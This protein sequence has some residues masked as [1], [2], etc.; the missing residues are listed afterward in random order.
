MSRQRYSR[1]FKVEAAKLVTEQGLSKAEAARRLGVT[2]T[3]MREWVDQ[4]G[5]E[6]G[7]EQADESAELKRLRE[8]NR[9]LR[10]EREILPLNV[11]IP[12]SKEPSFVSCRAPLRMYRSR[13]PLFSPSSPS[14]RGRGV[15]GLNNG[16][17]C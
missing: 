8:E 17:P 5:P 14:P 16:V 3:T 10:M 15:D 4:F 9:Q 1:Y 7:A 11:S 12:I 6:V 2:N 13:Q